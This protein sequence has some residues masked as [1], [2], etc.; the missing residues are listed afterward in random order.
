MCFSAEASF[1]VGSALIPAGA[2]CIWASLVKKPSYVGLA[3]VPLF[4]GVQQ[5]SEG[6]V[7][8][9]INHQESAHAPSLF[10]LFFALA[11]WPFWF[12]FLTTLMESEPRRRWIF[13]ALTIFASSWFWVLYFPLLMGPESI[14]KIEM[15]HHSIRYDYYDALPIY[16]YV[17]RP[18]LQL[19]YFA[20]V[21]L[22]MAFSTQSLGRIPG[23]ALGVSALVA[24]VV[25][26]HA[27]V[28]VW[29]F[30]AA[31]MSIYC[32]VMFYRLPSPVAYAAS[33][34]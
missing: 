21:A 10:F 32:C 7:W 27:F 20:C 12:P 17:K 23:I 11:F 15:A 4:F 16:D 34:A 3:A 8:Q 33:R 30:F 14:L 31:V 25:F 1:A 18:I 13:L 5:I 26:E 24:A 22:P 9:A 6:F 28:S 29:C 2:Y 19:L